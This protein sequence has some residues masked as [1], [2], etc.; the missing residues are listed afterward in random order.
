MRW[1]PSGILC[2]L[3]ALFSFLVG[4][5]PMI[6][7]YAKSMALAWWL[8]CS[9]PLRDWSLHVGFRADWFWEHATRGTVLADLAD[10]QRAEILTE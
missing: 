2:C 10:G 7:P 5:R 8:L 9:F 6:F 1:G 4:T 3:L